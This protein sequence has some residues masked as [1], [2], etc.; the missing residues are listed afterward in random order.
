[1]MMISADKI[2][3]VR[4]APLILVFSSTISSVAAC[5]SWAATWRLRNLCNSFSTP[6]KQ[7]KAPPIIKSGTISEGINTESNSASG[8]KI[9]L[10]T[11]EPL[12]TAHTIGSSRSARTPVT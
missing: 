6:S 4:M 5:G 1:M 9:S 8:T 3:S 10:L 12:V 11:K 7:R 2:K